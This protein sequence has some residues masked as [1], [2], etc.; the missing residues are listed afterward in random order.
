MLTVPKT[1]FDIPKAFPE[2]Y[3]SKCH[4]EELITSS[5]RFANPFC[6]MK[7]H[8]SLKLFAI[9]NIDYLG[10]NQPSI[11]HS[12]LRMTFSVDCQSV[13]MRDNRFLPLVA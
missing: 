2:R 1:G 10:E 8:T 3:L 11:V 5:H 13:Q 7:K 4:R 12:L 6:G 9:E